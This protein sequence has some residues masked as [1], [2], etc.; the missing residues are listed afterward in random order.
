MIVRGFTGGVFSENAYLV[1]CVG[2]GKAIIVDPGAAIRELLQV[3]EESALEVVAIVLT[4]AHIDHVD[5][6]AEAKRRTGAPIRLHAADEQLYHAAPLQ[7]QWFGVEVEPPPPLDGYL[8]EGDRVSFGGCDL[9][10]RFTPGHAPG[11]V[12]LV[13]EG[14]A[15]V[16]DCVFQGSIGRTDLPG[17]DFE[18]LMKSIRRQ[19]LTLSDET[20]LYPGHG[21]ET[22][23]GHERA[24]NPFLVPHLGGSSFA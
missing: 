16:G 13:G 6:A 2:S 10:V 4:H 9:E 1:S 8:A 7:G 22:T 15:L 23:V 20:V 12:V 11:H 14:M 3:A 17:G 21:P 19:I 5:G 24:T 18:T